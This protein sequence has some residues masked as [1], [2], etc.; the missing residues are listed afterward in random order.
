[1]SPWQP[2]H[3]FMGCI[4]LRCWRDGYYEETVRLSSSPGSQCKDLVWE[5]PNST[6]CVPSAQGGQGRHGRSSD[7]GCL[8]EDWGLG[9]GGQ[10]RESG[11]KSSGGREPDQA[12]EQCGIWGERAT[13]THLPWTPHWQR[14]RT[15]FPDKEETRYSV[16]P[17][18]LSHL[19]L[20]APHHQAR[21]SGSPCGN[22]CP[23]QRSWSHA[24]F[25]VMHRG[26]A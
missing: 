25:W 26:H 22:T 19:R 8:W 12:R 6:A 18:P 23:P 5:P 9:R 13:H 20:S 2:L 1:M 14:S 10:G 4:F 17:H 7:L 11:R 21:S 3:K 24:E 15:S 16:T